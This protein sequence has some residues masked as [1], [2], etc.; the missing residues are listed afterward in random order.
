MEAARAGSVDAVRLLLAHGAQVN[1]R[2]PARGQT[3]LMWAVSRQR[4]EIVKVLLENH[5]D[6][7]ARTEARPVMVML[8]T[9]NTTVPTM[10]ENFLIVTPNL[11]LPP[12]T[13][14]FESP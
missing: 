9:A 7:Q 14:T 2:E 4:P 10:G 13:L 6:V 8:D 12:C 3:A 5:A 11:V 1:A